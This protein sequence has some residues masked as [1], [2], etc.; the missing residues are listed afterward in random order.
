MRIAERLP[1]ITR[2]ADCHAH[3][4]CG[5]RFP[6]AEKTIYRPH[7]SQA[8]GGPA[9]LSVLDVH[10]LTHGLIVGANPYGMDNRCM[11]DAIAASRGRVKGIALID[12]DCSESELAKLAAQG[13][14]GC[15]INLYNQGLAPLEDPRAPHFLARLREAGWWVQLQCEKDQLAEVAPLLRKARVKIMVDHFGRP[16]VGRGI[17]QPGFQALLELGRSGDAVVK[18]SG[19][20]RASRE[21]YPHRDVDPFIAAAIEAFTLERCVWGSD[22]PFVRLDARVDYGPTLAC[23]MRWLPDAAYRDRVLWQT[24]ARLFGFTAPAD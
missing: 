10:G 19:P 16:D 20:F 8:G 17:E 3:V 1:V 15:R 14:I 5:D 12:P 24:P 7:P 2:G 18:L 22:W 6:F 11:L 21:A 23:L 13:V 9:F 4:F